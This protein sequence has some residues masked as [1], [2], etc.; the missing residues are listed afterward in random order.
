M[1][2]FLHEYC[3]SMRFGGEYAVGSVGWGTFCS[4]LYWGENEMVAW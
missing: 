1:R 3:R 4:G 2:C